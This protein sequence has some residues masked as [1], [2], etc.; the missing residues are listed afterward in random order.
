VWGGGG[1]KG[2]GQIQ[3]EGEMSRIGAHEVHKE[4]KRFFKKEKRKRN[5]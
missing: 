5:T 3:R 1:C 2:G 4:N